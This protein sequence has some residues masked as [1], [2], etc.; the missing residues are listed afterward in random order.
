VPDLVGWYV[1]GDFCAGMVWALEV[2][3]TGTSM[4]AGRQVELGPLPAVTAVV[5]GPQAEVY[6]LSGEGSV[7]RLDAPA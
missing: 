5:E 3:G 7:V 2:L 1:F 4:E 6:V